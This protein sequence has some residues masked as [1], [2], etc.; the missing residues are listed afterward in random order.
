MT[1][2]EKLQNNFWITFGIYLLCGGVLFVILFL[3]QTEAFRQMMLEVNKS[4]LTVFFSSPLG[5]VVLTQILA[6]GALGGVVAI[7]F[8]V[9]GRALVDMILDDEVKSKGKNK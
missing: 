1:F 7:L 6:L 5:V 2:R 4:G 8:Q 9:T 3:F